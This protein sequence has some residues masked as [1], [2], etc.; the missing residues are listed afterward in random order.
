MKGFRAFLLRGN[1]VDLA[2]G[3]VVG[4]AFTALVNGFV[5]A[6]LTPIV[7]LV[8]GA[9]GDFSHRNFHA[10]GVTFP[11]GVFINAAISFVIVAAVIYF[12]VVLPMN[13]M[14]EKF[15]P[16]AAS[17]PTRECPECLSAIP[18]AAKRCSACTAVLTPTVPAQGG[19]KDGAGVSD[20]AGVDI[21][22]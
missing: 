20:A 18:A 13:R 22:K 3:I 1:V 8:S 5:G 15:F 4:A 6:F 16:K 11:Y 10:S 2:V 9:T 7:G 19:E 14:Q 17:A 12:L 21:T